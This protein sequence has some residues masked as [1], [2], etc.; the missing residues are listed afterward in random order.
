MKT[1]SRFTGVLFAACMT[2]AS[3]P[4]ANA[5]LISTNT[6]SFYSMTGFQEYQPIADLVVN[7]TNVSVNYFSVYGQATGAA[8]LNWLLFDVTS[9]T[10]ADDYTIQSTWQSGVQLVGASSAHW[11]DSPILPSQ[12]STLLANHTYSL[13]IVADANFSWGK[14]IVGTDVAVGELTIPFMMGATHVVDP[15]NRGG[16]VC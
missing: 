15:T 14:N 9:G 1:M 4:A 12:Y 10:L 13:G 3:L 5:Q 7:N 11:Y 2:F 6:S 8:H 16:P